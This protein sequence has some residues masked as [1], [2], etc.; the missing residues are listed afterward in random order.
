MRFPIQREPLRSQVQEVLLERVLSG[1]LAPGENIRETELAEELGISRTPLREALLRLEHAGLVGYRQGR[2]FYVWP[3][4][5]EE[6]S[7]LYEI[8]GVLEGL[9]VRT[10]AGVRPEV[11][12][13]L[14]EANRRLEEAQGNPDVMIECDTRF[15]TLL[16]QDAGNRE[17]LEMIERT[18]NRLHRYRWYGYEYAV[19]HGSREKEK[20]VEE[21]RRIIAAI[22]AEEF[23]RAARLVDAHWARGIEVLTHWMR[24]GVPGGG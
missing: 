24:E 20:S 17:V 7:N 22:E 12:A 16:V 11:I 2:G 21:H 10:I 8:A 13:G 3:L 18:R 23:A 19:L 14:R 1:A 5:V 15:H 9:A 4:S 6:A